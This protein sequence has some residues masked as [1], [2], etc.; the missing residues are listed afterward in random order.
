MSAAA[1]VA[2]EVVADPHE[3]AR[4]PR[5]V[6]LHR[7][8]QVRA[9][10]VAVV[11]VALGTLLFCLSI[12]LGEFPIPLV[13]VLPAVF[14]VGDPDAD[15][16][17]RTL[18]LPRALAAVLVG[19]CFG[20]SGALVQAL[21]RNPLASP[22]IIGITSGASAAAV[23]VIVV[24][25]GTGAMV[26]FG[27][28]AGAL[29]TATAI[30]L[31]AYRRGISSYRLVL[32][33]IGLGAVLTSTTS[34]LLTRADIFNAQQ[35]TVWLTG[36]LN[37]MTWDQ[38]RPLV[39]ASVVLVPG[40]LLV[41]LELRMLLLGDDTAKGLGVHVERARALVLLVAVA[42]AA[43]ATA[44]AGPVAFVAFLA[45]PVARRLVDS[46]LAVATSG[47]VGAVLLLGADVIAHNL[48]PR[49]LPVGIVTGLIGAPYLLVL[50]ARTNRLGRGG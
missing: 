8:S 39:V 44:V 38:L 36:S 4:R 34:Y 22:D 6:Q 49:D 14:G 46:P 35:A 7:R 31:L 19:L 43:V 11:L 5:L 24:L 50:L 25:A 40:A 2:E 29:L 27:A 1:P 18:R 20:L 23:F 16:I 12:S 26:S 47:L 10:I 37:G 17:I 3:A 21:A 48:L 42:L 13:D 45:A 28:F 32:V 9:T 30:Y 41:V 15:F 33:G